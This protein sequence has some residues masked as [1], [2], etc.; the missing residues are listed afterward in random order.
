MLRK[1]WRILLIFIM[2]LI[3]AGCK[4]VTPEDIIKGLR[5]IDESLEGYQCE[6][7][8]TYHCCNPPL[9]FRLKEWFKKPGEFGFE[10]L[11]P[12]KHRGNTVIFTDRSIVL[13]YPGIQDEREIS[14]TKDQN[15]LFGQGVFLKKRLENI[16]KSADSL[17]ISR[18]LQDGRTWFIIELPAKPF[19]VFT[20]RE[21]IWL[22]GKTFLPHRVEIWTKEGDLYMTIEYI[23]VKFNKTTGGI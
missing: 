14:I 15:L 9:S 13:K 5:E 18:E 8:L 4:E 12:G 22:D 11:E 10:T 1:S 6:I 21:K 23:N 7:K 19:T 16:L 2:L 17:S 3:P 20:D